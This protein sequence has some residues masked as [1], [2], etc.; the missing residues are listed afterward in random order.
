MDLIPAFRCSITFEVMRDPVMLGSS[1]HTFE[2]SAI[3]NW[4]QSNNTNPLTNLPLTPHTER[5]LTPNISLR[6]AINQYVEKVAPAVLKGALENSAEAIIERATLNLNNLSVTNFNKL[7]N[8]FL[9]II[10]IG[11]GHLLAK[12]VALLVAKAQMEEHFC[13]MCADLCRKICN[14]WEDLVLDS[15][16]CE[17][18]GE[19]TD[20]KQMTKGK[21]FR[22]LLLDYCRLEFETGRVK[23]LE[24]I[25][26]MVELT[27]EERLE[28]E[29][30][31][32]KRYTG[33]MCFIG[34][35]YMKDLVLATI[36]N[37]HCLSVL[38]QQTDEEQLVC[39]CKLFQTVGNK[40][41]KYYNKR[42][43]GKNNKERR[44]DEII[45]G[46]FAAIEKIALTHPNSRVRFMLRELIEMRANNWTACREDEKVVDISEARA[47]VGR[48]LGPSRG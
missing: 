13:S 30:L 19:G 46:H 28:K 20:G 45:P 21:L 18:D 27:E 15:P 9:E 12:V 17:S 3:E 41:E 31:L 4:L 24:E 1:G 26:T 40:I 43:R 39:L 5:T 35:L 48:G 32:K 44:Y 6:D 2:R 42:A 8:E 10:S 11:D 33:H 34:E 25:R 29:L 38:V 14:V 16:P 37:E 36:I 23:G 7:S 22:E 47:V